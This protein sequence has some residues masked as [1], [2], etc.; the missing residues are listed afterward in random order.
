MQMA[1]YRDNWRA[2]VDTVMKILVP[3][4]CSFNENKTTGETLNEF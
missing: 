4:N 2:L 1:Q 3:L